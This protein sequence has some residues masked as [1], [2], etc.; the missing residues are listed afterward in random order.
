[1]T[2]Y[3]Q[4]VLRDGGDRLGSRL[5]GRFAEWVP[6]DDDGSTHVELSRGRTRIALA[7][8]ESCGRYRV[9]LPTGPGRLRTT[10]T[11]AKDARGGGWVAF[12]IEGELSE[13]AEPVRAPALLPRFL[14]SGRATDGAIPLEAAAHL[15][16]RDEVDQLLNWL[17]NPRRNV[18]VIVLT[19]D[20]SDAEIVAGH[21]DLLA[22]RLA[23]IAVV[24]RLYDVSAQ[25]LLNRRLGADLTVFGGGLRTYLPG[26]RPGEERYPMRH[27]PRGGK[28]LRDQG[29]RAL[30]VVFDGVIDFAVHRPLPTDV[31][32]ADA[33]ID[34]VLAGE[35][36]PDQLHAAPPNP[37]ELIRA[38]NPKA[39]APMSAEPRVSVAESGP[40]VS[41]ADNESPVPKPRKAEAAESTQIDLPEPAGT[42]ASSEIPSREADRIAD[43]VSDLVTG[44]LEDGI[45]NALDI[46]SG[47][48]ETARL[49]RG[50]STQMEA[51][52]GAIDETNVLRDRRSRGDHHKRELDRLRREYDQLEA[53]YKLILDAERRGV[54]RIRWLEARL[55]EHADPVYGVEQPGEVWEADSLMEVVL[56]ARARLEHLELPETLDAEVAK[57]DV[58]HP[59][60][61]RRWT[62]KTWD[63]LR[64]LDAYAAARAEGRFTGGFYDW[65]CRPLPGKPAITPTMVSMKESE[66]VSG[67]SKF[68]DARTFRVPESIDPSGRIYMPSHIKLQQVGSPAPRMHFLDDAG[69]TTGRVWIGYLGDHLPNT[70][71][72]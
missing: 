71:T 1:M 29:A 42:S 63:A 28:A 13:D 24:A 27:Q 65:C 8:S 33:R 68:R 31:R 16:G 32:Q 45:L 61:R 26:L 58:T 36:A 54:E 43:R 50:L 38:R 18:P 70:R 47:D 2:L 9:D 53:E 25:D 7:D 23:G 49:V 14:E 51:L 67:R 15:I 57:L 48:T 40:P 39:P 37:A 46:G 34:R 66:T 3:Y 10:A 5:R 41:A 60:L 20:R 11:W 56:R 69:G 64:A 44:K 19:V 62:A 17:V 12:T 72:N 35:L 22:E 55:A 59:R 4:A 6:F 52:V 30:E 21:A